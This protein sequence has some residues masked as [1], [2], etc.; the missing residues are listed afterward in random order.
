MIVLDSSLKLISTYHRFTN[1]ELGLLFVL[2][3]RRINF[4]WKLFTL[5]ANDI[6]YRVNQLISPPTVTRLIFV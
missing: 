2:T 4:C 1:T 3:V 5:M 6:I